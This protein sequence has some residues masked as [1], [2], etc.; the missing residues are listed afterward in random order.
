MMADEV[1][2]RL[3]ETTTEKRRSATEWETETE[4]FACEDAC[5]PMATMYPVTSN[6]AMGYQWKG[7][8]PDYNTEE[9]SARNESGFV[10]RAAGNVVADRRRD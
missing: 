9:Y 10:Q 3:L 1:T 2:M 6:A 8:V 5:M 4:A 7:S